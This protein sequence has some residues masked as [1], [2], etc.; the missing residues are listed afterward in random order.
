MKVNKLEGPLL[1]APGMLLIF[2]IMI[3]PLFYTIYC[4]MYSLDYMQFGNFIG[5]N[6]YI[7]ILKDPKLWPSIRVTFIISL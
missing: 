1:V 2:V 6:N 5:L 7:S 4:S 3:F